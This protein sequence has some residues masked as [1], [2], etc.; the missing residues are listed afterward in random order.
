MEFLK[1]FFNFDPPKNGFICG[2]CKLCNVS[3]KDKV[4]STGNFHKH[5]RRRHAKEYAEHREVESAASDVE[6]N[7]S[8]EYEG[9]SYDD[10]VNQSIVLNLIVRCN[11]PPSMVEHIG[12]RKFMSDVVRKWRP[13]SAR[14][15]KAR[16][17]PP[18][19]AS[20]RKKVDSMLN[21]IDHLSVTVDIWCDRRG[22]AFFGVTDHFIDVDF[23][24]HAVLLRFVRL[25]GKH[26]AENIRNVTKDIL[27]ELEI[28]RKIY[29]VITDN[30]S[31]M[32]KTCK[33]GL[34]S[35]EENN[36]NNSVVIVGSDENS[37]NSSSTD[38]CDSENELTLTDPIQEETEDL[39]GVEETN[40]R[41]SCFAHSLQLA[42]R[43]G[44]SNV[45]YL[46]K[47][48]AKCKQ[49]SQKSHKSTK[50]ADILDDVDKR[51]T[52][53]NT[54]RW[55]SEYFLIRSILRIGKKTIQDITSAIDDDA[56]SF[57][58]SDFNVLEEV[59]EILEPFADITIICQSE[60]TAT[61]SMVVPAIVHLV[62]HLKQM[63]SKTSLLRKLVVQLDQSIKTRF[64]GI[65]KRLSLEPI[66]DND[67]F[68]DP[69]YFVATLLDP[70]FKLRWIY[71]LDYAPSLQSKLK[72]AMMSLVLDE[73][74]LNPNMDVNQTST[75]HSCFS[76]S[77]TSVYR[78]TESKKRKLFQY[79]E[80]D[81][82]FSTNAELNPIDEL[83]L[84]INDSNH[85]SS[86]SSWK[87]SFLSSL[88]AVVKRVFSVQA[89]SA[90]IERVFSQSGLLMSSRRTSMG[91]ELF[92]SL[93][94]LRVNQHLL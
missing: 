16:V 70:K 22:K 79:D 87:S 5:L 59:I 82:P 19:Y 64:S 43:D 75:Q 71:L 65:V 28:S 53:S 4:G 76:S 94:F 31:N 85:I 72:H 26:T 48:L 3:Y 86:L 51:L 37:V 58:S 40:R 80:H 24:P 83:N 21:E 23:K 63:N 54:T 41:L 57:S 55:S 77:G 10:K 73:C 61:I 46:S 91:D 84:Y 25:K 6:T 29:R 15:L 35:C 9:S 69:L 60:T 2:Y 32:I 12:F 18:L 52:R 14:Y 39:C 56:L 13:A 92:E 93:V 34:T 38:V 89:S 50:V 78:M 20:V 30:E 45:S 7:V 8:L 62:H 88:A 66:S 67:P 81:G 33:F 74:E 27:E 11:L 36:L 17:I 90:P 49:L 44:L 68:S 47:T 42:I 1:V